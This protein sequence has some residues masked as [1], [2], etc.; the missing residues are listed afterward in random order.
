MQDRS[1]SLH[2]HD[3]RRSRRLHGDHLR[4]AGDEVRDDRV[5]TQS[6]ALDEDS[7]LPGWSK[8]G[9][10]AALLQ[11]ASELKHHRH[12]SDVGVGADGENHRRVELAYAA[13]AN[14]EV[15]GRHSDVVHFDSA[16][17]SQ[18]SE[19]GVGRYEPVE[20]IPDRHST[21]D[22]VPDGGP[23]LRAEAG[24]MRRD[25]DEERVRAERESIVN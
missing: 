16:I 18:R 6:P 4:R 19:L 25:A 11:R 9:S 23:Q 24:T 10:H 13:S 21:I 20:T 15:V 5:N 1:L 17:A 8:A 7:R 3:V 2:E 12:L 22:R 14:R